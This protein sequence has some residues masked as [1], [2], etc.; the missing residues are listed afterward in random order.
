MLN[1]KEIP[2]LP[3]KINETHCHLDYLEDIPLNEVLNKCFENQINKILTISVS[4]E[5]LKT[6]RHL[7]SSHENV[8]GTQGIHPHQAKNYSPEVEKE[9]RLHINDS[10]ITAVGEIGLDYYYNNSPKKQQLQVFERQLELA[11]EF[12]MPV[13][14]HSRDADRDTI[15]ILNHFSP[16][17][18]PNHSSLG[19]IHSFTSGTELAKFSLDKGFYLGFNGIITFK[20]A[21]KVRDIVSLCPLEKMLVE[22]DSPFLTPH[23]FR[24]RENAPFYIPLVVLKISEIKKIPVEKCIESLNENSKVFFN[25]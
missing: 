12:K 16:K 9:I 20:N 7:S 23:P 10:K 11:V 6:V 21:Q 8:F 19:V 25:S 22:T 1:K 13:V 24:G 5:N 15:N 4:P 18:T 3:G 2:K 17:M 14:I